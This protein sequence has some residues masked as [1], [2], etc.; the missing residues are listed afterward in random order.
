MNEIHFSFIVLCMLLLTSPTSKKKGEITFHFEIGNSCQLKLAGVS[1]MKQ[2]T[3]IG[4]TNFW[5]LPET[6]ELPDLGRPAA[7][8]LKTMTKNISFAS[9]PV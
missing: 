2:V 8:R 1:G 4:R 5:K 3:R 7:Y 9:L 6:T